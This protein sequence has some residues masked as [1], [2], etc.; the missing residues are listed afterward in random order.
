MKTL[1]NVANDIRINNETL[2]QK[3]RDEIYKSLTILNPAYVQAVKMDKYTGYMEKFIYLYEPRG[4]TLI[5]PRGY[6]Y[7]LLRLLKD[8]GQEHAIDDQRLLLPPV[9]YHSK[10]ELRPYQVPAAKRLVKFGNGG[11]VAPCGSGKT[12]IMLAVMAEL[13]QPA[14]WVTHTRELVNQVIERALASF[15]GMTREEIGTITEGRVSIGKRL[16]VALVQTLSKVDIEPLLDKFGAVF[17]DEGHHI[18]A[19]TFLVPIGQFPARY[20]LWCS[21]TPEREDGLTQMVLASGGSVL[22]TIPD[23]DLPT[24]TPQLRIIETA[25]AGHVDVDDYP[26][27]ISGLIKNDERN[28]LISST[29]TREAPGHYSLILG[30]R[31]DHLNTLKAMLKYSLP[32]TNIELLTGQL[33]KKERT[34]IMER[35]KNRQVDILLATQLAREGLD[36][37]HLDR[38]FLVS[39]KKGLAATEQEIGRIRRPCENKPDA[40][41]FDFWDTGNPIFKSQFW[42]RKAVYEKLGINV[43]L[44]HGIERIR[45]RVS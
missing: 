15:E 36:L 4:D 31:I 17:V 20:R 29:I 9:D 14:L 16:T 13:K 45:Q 41:V 11:L 30:D 19:K 3:I 25:Y 21:A 33:P 22:Y 18:A 2:T 24:I 23:E 10:I 1:I 40:V 7:R 39:P 43:D 38:L 8:T 12:E 5:I 44:K 34:A 27:M 6:I 37:P 28:R 26:G 32:D 42:K 35:A